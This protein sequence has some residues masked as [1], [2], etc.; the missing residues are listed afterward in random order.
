MHA[1]PV[2]SLLFAATFWGIVWYPLRLLADAGI[3]GLWQ[4]LISY[5]VAA[6]VVL[7]AYWSRR[8]ELRGRTLS[9]VPLA[10]ATGWCNVGFM[11]GMIEGTVLRVLLLFYLAPVWAVLIA[12]AVLGERLAPRTRVALPM[13][14]LGAALM[15]Y[16][17][18]LGLPLP[19]DRADWLGLSAGLAFAV[20]TVETRRLQAV[21]V[22]AKTLASWVGVVL[23]AAAG[24]G[25]GGQAFPDAPPGAWAGLVALGAS[26]FLAAT[27]AVQFGAT[28][29]PVQ[30][31]TVILLLEIVVGAVSAAWL[32]AEYTGTK[33]W[34]GG[35]LIAGA[36]LVA[37]RADEVRRVE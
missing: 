29:L 24:I 8:A 28:R 1:L 35:L 37:A 16:D 18:S 22:T 13:A 23:V 11:L 4:A 7:P 15:L 33:E 17:P 10:F 21:S 30:R 27:L 2:L 31:T 9:L 25:A 32:A 3:T 14:L 19:A 36:G 34:V 5:L 6:A 12:R 20:T 26:G